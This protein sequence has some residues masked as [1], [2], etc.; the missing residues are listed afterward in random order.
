MLKVK[1]YW[2]VVLF[3]FAVSTLMS[4]CSSIANTSNS[5]PVAVIDPV[6]VDDKRTIAEGESASWKLESGNYKL[7]MTA[8]GDGARVEWV[9]SE[10]PETKSTK[11]L[12]VTCEMQKTGQMVITNHSVIG[13]G[14]SVSVTVKLTKVA[15]L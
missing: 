1:K 12:T 3:V 6:V 15:V 8:S 4:G 5:R 2:N 13:A 11:N 10:C 7:E 14:D 9:G